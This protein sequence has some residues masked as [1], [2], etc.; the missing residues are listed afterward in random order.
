MAVSTPLKLSGQQALELA[1]RVVRTV[2]NTT[3]ITAPPD[4]WL[5]R[6]VL[7]TLKAAGIIEP[8]LNGSPVDPSQ[9]SY[10]LD[11]RE[12]TVDLSFLMSRG[13]LVSSQAGITL[14]SHS[15]AEEAFKS[16]C[17]VPHGSLTHHWSTLFEG[18]PC[19]GELTDALSSLPTAPIESERRSH[20]MANWSEI[21]TGFRL[22]PI[23]L[24]LQRAGWTKEWVAR[25]DLPPKCA[26]RLDNEAGRQV[27]HILAQSG[28]TQSADSHQ[29]TQIGRRVLERGP[30]PFGI[31][32]A[33]HPY[34]L[35]LHQILEKAEDRSTS[36]E[37]P[38]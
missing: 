8:L 13:Y 25:G 19:P 14:S 18:Q 16:I 15:S 20:W 12:L 9:D 34:M 10:G 1:L 4:L 26:A 2:L 30:G 32:E 38:M 7:A 21:E 6:Q 33:Y 23:I 24:G 37:P 17:P 35:Q 31:I 29:L 11:P 3:A 36:L 5:L 22:V 27:G 28:I